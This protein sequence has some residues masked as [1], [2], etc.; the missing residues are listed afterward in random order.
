MVAG[1]GKVA[2]AAGK[3]LE[4]IDKEPLYYQDIADRFSAYDFQTIARALGMLHEEQKL[5]QTAEGRMCVKGSRFAA[6][7]PGSGAA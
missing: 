4:A 3:I 5:W 6:K 1:A 2:Q 7:L